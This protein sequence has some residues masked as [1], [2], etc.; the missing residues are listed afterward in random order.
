MRAKTMVHHIRGD[1]DVEHIS[2]R[3]NENSPRV[4]K[5]I[6]L[7]VSPGEFVA[8]VG[9][10]GSGKSTL[11]RIF[12]G[13]E[14]PESGSVYYDGQDMED[15]D[16]KSVRRQMGVVLQNGQV[17]PGNILK[18]ITGALNLTLDDA[19]E[20]ARMVGLEK[21]IEAMPMGMYTVIS[22]GGGNLSG[23]QR[24][25]LIIARA[26]V[27]KPRILFFDEATSA[28]DNRAQAV[29]SKSIER[30]NVTRVVIA[31]RLSTIINADRIYVLG[32]RRNDGIGNL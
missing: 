21:D 1:M 10:S 3:Y 15:L 27:R 11:L 8:I 20:A 5:D 29:V 14:K 19:W 2:F 13:F 16:I 4:L 26:I 22:A 24:Q 12:L 30:L 28:L 32:A 25:R 6:N 23:G 31:H 7:R 9:G 18:N 17:M